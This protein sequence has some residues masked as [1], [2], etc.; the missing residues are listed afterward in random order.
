MEYYAHGA[1]ASPELVA[2]LIKDKGPWADAV[3]SQC[4]CVPKMVRQALFNGEAEW[5]VPNFRTIV[6]SLPESR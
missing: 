1:H 3:L 6:I 5:T 4:F 2:A